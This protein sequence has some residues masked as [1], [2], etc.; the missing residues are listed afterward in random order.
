M[1]PKKKINKR[2]FFDIT[3][4]VYV[5]TLYS[6]EYFHDRNRYF[7]FLNSFSKMKCFRSKIRKKLYSYVL[8]HLNRQIAVHIR[9]EL[10]KFSLSF[11]SSSCAVI[12]DI[13]FVC[14]HITAYTS[15]FM[16]FSG[17]IIFYVYFARFN[18]K[19][20]SFFFS[21]FYFIINTLFW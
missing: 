19:K 6:V 8:I 7:S 1:N 17:E 11:F 13:Y 10:T 16:C 14:H 5:P 20:R 9:L 4:Q 21:I 15:T 12:D 2:I 18:P 3:H